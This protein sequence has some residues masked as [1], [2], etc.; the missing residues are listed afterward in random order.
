MVLDLAVRADQRQFA[1][2]V[3]VLHVAGFAPGQQPG[4]RATGPQRLLGGGAGLQHGVHRGVSLQP[5]QRADG[6]EDDEKLA[7]RVAGQSVGRSYPNRFE[8]LLTVGHWGLPGWHAR[9]QKRNVETSRQVA[10]GDPVRQ[11]I[12]RVGSQQ[13]VPCLALGGKGLAA[14]QGCDVLLVGGP[15]VGVL[16]QQNAKFFKALPDGRNGLRQVQRTLAGATRRQSMAG[17]IERVDAAARE[18]IGARRKAGRQ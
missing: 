10:V 11:H 13:Q 17:G 5:L 14:V 6:R 18:H 9:H 8:L 4:A 16:R 15:A 12:H 2:G 7:G 3:L 1:I